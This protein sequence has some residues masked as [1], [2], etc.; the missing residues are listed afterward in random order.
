LPAVPKPAAL[1]AEDGPGLPVPLLAAAAY[2]GAM[3]LGSR[4]LEGRSLASEGETVTPVLRQVSSYPV[5]WVEATEWQ[6]LDSERFSLEEA[7]AFQLST[8]DLFAGIVPYDRPPSYALV[9]PEPSIFS[10]PPPR[11]TKLARKIKFLARKKLYQEVR[12]QLRK[13]WKSQYRESYTISYQQ[14]HERMVQITNVGKEET[15]IDDL[16]FEYTTD[17]VREDLF[18]TRYQDGERE[19]PLVS[20][21]L[22]TL[23]DSGAVSFDLAD[24][25]AEDD[26]IDDEP[27]KIAKEKEERKPFLA[28]KGYRIDTSFKLDVNPMRIYRSGEPVAFIESYGVT[29]EIDWLSDVLARDVISA[30]IEIEVDDHK[31][32][33]GFFNI[34]IKSRK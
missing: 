7:E 1:E 9:G 21:G 23:M 2:P 16:D 10:I 20:V 3:A 24:V 33:A 34:V 8:W 11:E 5:P 15:D 13:Q 27:V 26:D 6:A 14:Y 4:S 18:P 28:D 29:V 25:A 30:E 32:I 12:R 31:D 19:I 22:F 17:E